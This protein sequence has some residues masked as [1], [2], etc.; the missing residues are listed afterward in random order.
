MIQSLDFIPGTVV[1]VID[2]GISPEKLDNAL[3]LKGINL[4]D[5]G[6][7]EDTND[8]GNH[9]TA[10]ATTILHIAPQCQLIPIKL[11]NRRGVLRD[12][13]KLEMALDWILEH[14]LDLNIKIICAAFA[15]FSHAT[16]D[17]THRGTRIQ[18]HIATLREMNVATVAPAG[19]WYP[20]HCRQNP[21]GMAWPAILREVLSVGAAQQKNNDLWLTKGSQ[22]LHTSLNTGC[23]TTVFTEPGEPGETSGAA[24]VIAGCLAALQQAC[25]VSTVDDLVQM[26]L[27]FQQ[28]AYDASGLLWPT[29]K[30]KK[31]LLRSESFWIH[32]P[33]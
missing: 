18:Q 1:A 33:P 6:D 26:L 32:S 11:M 19:N 30:L 20:E 3:V 9:G 5:E 17:V 23:Q 31:I 21:Q 2:T 7:I 8:Y 12:P 15:D 25:P 4:S 27:P 24:A 13:N 22:R 10:I 14:Q 16:S 28:V 29:V